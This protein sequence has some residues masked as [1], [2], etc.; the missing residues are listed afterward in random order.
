MTH[1]DYNSSASIKDF[2][3]KNGLAMQKKFGQNFLINEQARKKIIDALDVNQNTTVWEVGPG[4]GCMTDEILSR[5]ASITVFEI[6]KGFAG[7]VS[8][9]FSDYEQNGKFNLVEGDVLKTWKGELER[10]KEKNGGRLPDR[11]FGN[12]PYNIAAT[13]IA[14]TIENDVRFE[15]CVFTIQKEVAK[16]M[17]AQPG[18]DDYSSFSVLCSWAYDVSNIIDLSGANFWPKP[19][20][21]SRAVLLTK[22]ASFPNCENPKLFCKMQRALFSSRRKTIKN[23]LG[24]FLSS[25]DKAA[26]ALAKAELDPSLRAEVLSVEQML[27]LSD[28]LNKY[29]IKK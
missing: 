17:T 7:C 16:R 6:D 25:Q 4:L 27:V 14:D 15:K 23:N 10:Y 29:I 8:Q 2:L 28:V 22:K 19:N 11:F 5:D 3:D 1:P 13:L 12:L 9:F 24:I 20:V 18:S 26:E 21:D